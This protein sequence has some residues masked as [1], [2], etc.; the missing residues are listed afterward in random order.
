MKKINS[1]NTNVYDK[2]LKENADQLFIRYIEKL[3]PSPILY[4][5]I[6]NTKLQITTEREVDY[7]YEVELKNKSRFLLHLEFQTEMG[8]DMIFRLG[9]YHGIL[10]R[11]YKLPIEHFVVYLGNKKIRFQNQLDDQFI[12]KSFHL[13]NMKELDP[14]PFLN[15][16]HPEEVLLSILCKIPEEQMDKYLRLLT[17][18]L[19]VLSSNKVK[20]NKFVQQLLVLTRLRNIN[21][22]SI[23]IINDM[24]VTIDINKDVLYNRGLSE[25]LE[26]GMDLGLEK[27]MDLGLEKGMGLGLE[28]GINLG[29]EKREVETIQNCLNAQYSIKEISVITALSIQK[30]NALIKK[31]KIKK[32]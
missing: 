23:K 17:E 20:I 29:I 9:E 28:K 10:T 19:I 7:L 25:G 32:K 26:K 1:D 30:I 27:G 16:K 22:Q 24:P 8:L 15:S 12:F 6:L 21:E 3:L 4:K 2:I 31:Y 5:K 13:I 11:K 14:E 18:R